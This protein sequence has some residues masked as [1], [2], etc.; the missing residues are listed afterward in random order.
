MLVQPVPAVGHRLLLN[1]GHA[2][3]QF[4]L[5]PLDLLGGQLHTE[6]VGRH[7]QDSHVH[8]ELVPDTAE[9][10]VVV[11]I[12][13]ITQPPLCLQHEVIVVGEELVDQ[14]LPLTTL[15]AELGHERQVVGTGQDAGAVDAPRQGVLGEPL[16]DSAGLLMDVGQ[17]VVERQQ[18]LVV[19]SCTGAGTVGIGH[20]LGGLLVQLTCRPLRDGQGHEK[21]TVVQL[22][23]KSST[24]NV[25]SNRCWV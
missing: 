25:P 6:V 24:L 7:R 3:F 18:R 1:A 8:V 19:A 12:V 13:E 5:Q 20:I 23:W 10:G 2:T 11:G 16:T 22:H 21:G 9:I 15:T 14:S 4:L 17:Q